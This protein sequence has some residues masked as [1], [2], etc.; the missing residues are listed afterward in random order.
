[1]SPLYPHNGPRGLGALGFTPLS[2]LFFFFCAWNGCE[3]SAGSDG[4]LTVHGALRPN[5]KPLLSASVQPCVTA[6]VGVHGGSKR[7][8]LTHAGQA[9]GGESILLNHLIANFGMAAWMCAIPVGAHP[10]SSAVLG[11][12]YPACEGCTDASSALMEV[13]RTDWMM[14]HASLSFPRCLRERTWAEPS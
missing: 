1:M 9:I 11:G 7:N 10:S 2:A 3:C 13:D 12:G 5:D 14:A 4:W 8:L 6:A